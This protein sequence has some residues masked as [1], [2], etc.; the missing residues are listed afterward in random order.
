MNATKIM[1]KLKRKRWCLF[2][3]LMLVQHT[4]FHATT[5]L[6]A[7][8]KYKRDDESE[9]K[10]PF[11]LSSVFLTFKIVVV[12]DFQK[13]KNFILF[14]VRTALTF[15]CVW[16]WMYGYSIIKCIFKLKSDDNIKRTKKGLTKGDSKER[17]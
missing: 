8:Q 9:K 14:L 16:V 4:L 11:T 3:S 1:W 17:A 7:I 2:D 15:S 12:V 6:R 5:M 13:N 10:I